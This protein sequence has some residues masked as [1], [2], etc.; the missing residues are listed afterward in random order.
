MYLTKNVNGFENISINYEFCI[1]SNGTLLHKAFLTFMHDNSL[2]NSDIDLLFYIKAVKHLQKGDDTLVFYIF[3]FIYFFYN[4]KERN[5]TLKI[6]QNLQ[7]SLCNH[8]IRYHLF[9]TVIPLSRCYCM[10]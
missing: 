7:T 5:F 6:Y 1:M 8:L 3:S 2:T 10:I 9:L 4:L